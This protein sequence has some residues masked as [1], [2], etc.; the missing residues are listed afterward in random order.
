MKLGGDLQ[1]KDA[2]NFILDKVGDPY[3]TAYVDHISIHP[4]A[5][6]APHSIIPDLYAQNFPVGRWRVNDSGA[7]SSTDEFLRPKHM[8]HATVDINNNTMIKPH[9]RQ[10]REVVNQYHCKFE[11]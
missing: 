11:K 7:I 3:I 6:K 5:R 10:A 2:V 4:N 9:E 1:E 8:Q